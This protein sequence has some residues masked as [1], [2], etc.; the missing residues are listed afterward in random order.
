[1]MNVT[2]VIVVGPDLD[3][4]FF[5][6]FIEQITFFINRKFEKILLYQYLLT[7]YTLQ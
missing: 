7:R 5:L 4:P 3:F 2:V 1:M 6:T